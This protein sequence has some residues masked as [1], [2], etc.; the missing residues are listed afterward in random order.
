MIENSVVS[1]LTEAPTVAPDTSAMAVSGYLREPEVPAV[2]VES[3]GGEL[4]GVV[5][6]SDVVAA[7]AEGARNPRVESFMSAPVVTVPPETEV[8]LAADRMRDAGVGL[9]PVVDDGGYCGVVTKEALA[10][11]LSRHR[12]EVTWKGDPLSLG[13]SEEP[14]ADGRP[15]DDPSAED[16][17]GTEESDAPAPE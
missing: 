5:T 14:P 6:E 7:V 2:V 16:A 11:Y 12:L 13:G 8:G 1:L 10:P 15:V 4:A 3:E 17:S 9:L